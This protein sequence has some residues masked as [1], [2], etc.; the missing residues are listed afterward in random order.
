MTTN[1]TSTNATS[2]TANAMMRPADA[3]IETAGWDEPAGEEE[4]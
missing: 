3:P 1:A 2:M 4:A